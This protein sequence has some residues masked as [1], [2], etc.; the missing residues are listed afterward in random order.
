MGF[1]AQTSTDR[2]VQWILQIIVFQ[3]REFRFICL[4]IAKIANLTFYLTSH[5]KMPNKGIPEFPSKLKL[6]SKIVIQSTLLAKILTG[7]ISNLLRLVVYSFRLSQHAPS[8]QQMRSPVPK[9]F[10]E[11]I[12]E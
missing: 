2:T 8:H 9:P 1:Q 5:R 4:K 7:M 12:L 3:I 10:L 6:R 11:H